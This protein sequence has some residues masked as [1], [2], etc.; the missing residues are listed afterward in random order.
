LIICVSQAFGPAAPGPQAN[1]SITTPHYRHPFMSIL[2]A[3]T[4][5][6]KYGNFAVAEIA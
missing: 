4:V 5:A 2:L 3:A 6:D 1:P